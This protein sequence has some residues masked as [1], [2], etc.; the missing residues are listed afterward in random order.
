MARPSGRNSA[1]IALM[2]VDDHPIWRDSLRRVLEHRR[3]GTVVAEADDGERAVKI[4]LSKRLDVIVMDMYLP[5]LG[6]VEA[7]R[8]ILAGRPETKILV[9]SAS[10]RTADVLGA[11][12]AGVSGYLLKTAHPREVADAVLR[13][14][15][16]EVVL[17]SSVAEVVLAEVRRSSDT[18]RGG[19]Q[20]EPDAKPP[21]TFAREGEYWTLSFEQKTIRLRDSRGLGYLHELLRHPRREIHVADL[22]T[23]STATG[24]KLS[25]G[26][27][28]K[29]DGLRSPSGDAGPLLDAKA[30]AD[31]ARRL[32]ELDEDLA[33]A[34][35]WGDEERAARIQD[36]MGAL[37]AQLSSAYGLGGRP[38]KAGDVTERMRKSVGNR[39]RDAIARIEAQHPAL[40]RH[41]LTSITTGTFCSYSPDEQVSWSL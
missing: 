6:G 36:E 40:G 7:T 29:D 8:R 37:S 11:V 20:A 1:G 4:A 39:I 17:P 21:S 5:T 33:E 24:T 25:T 28:V 18:Q 41:L 34:R 22:I 14:H 30:R 10:D 26:P 31:Y 35:E 16:G 32:R 23:I 13:V 3:I 2:L 27:R 15:R 19:D 9:L 38:R 12:R